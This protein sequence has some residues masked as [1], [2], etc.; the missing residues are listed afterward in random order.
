MSKLS[1]REK[2]RIHIK[3]QVKIMEYT[4]I[5][6]RPQDKNSS[7]DGVMYQNKHLLV[8]LLKKKYSHFINIAVIFPGIGKYTINKMLLL[9]PLHTKETKWK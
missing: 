4:L 7:S 8:Y 5:M 9:L 2:S 1:K 6:K 3:D